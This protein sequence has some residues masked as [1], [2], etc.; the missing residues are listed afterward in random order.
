MKSIIIWGDSNAGKTTSCFKLL[1]ILIALDARIVSYQTFDCGDFCAT[2]LF[3]GFKIA[4]YSAG[5]SKS[6]FKGA[7]QYGEEE[8][9]DILVGVLSSG[10]HYSEALQKYEQDKDY[11][12]YNLPYTEADEE[13]SV[14]ENHLIV[15]VLE[16]IY[17]ILGSKED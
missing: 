13:K 10:K 14:S 15:T 17:Q 5:D 11:F 3:E 6:W 7:L 8:C 2:L 9:V 1:K 4:I 12:W 16:K